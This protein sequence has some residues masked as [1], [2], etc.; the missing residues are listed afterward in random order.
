M[1]GRCSCPPA[2]K[3]HQNAAVMKPR[4]GDTIWP[5]FIFPPL[6]YL[7]GFYSSSI[8]SLGCSRYLLLNSLRDGGYRILVKSLYITLFI[9]PMKIGLCLIAKKY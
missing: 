8:H 4:G 2:S 6:Q 9:C 1:Q 7:S 5:Y 3:V